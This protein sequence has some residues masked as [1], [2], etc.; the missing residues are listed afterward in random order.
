MDLRTAIS[1]VEVMKNFYRSIEYIGEVLEVA[2]GAEQYAAERSAEAQK[3]AE[4]IVERRKELA[5]VEA[6]TAKA[7]EEQSKQRREHEDALV[8]AEEQS[9]KQRAARMNEFEANFTKAMELATK[10]REALDAAVRR[11]ANIKA[12][13]EVEVAALTNELNHLKSR[14]AGA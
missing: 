7:R 11:L 14:I 10:Q 2:R 3:T 12:E 9:S 1:K 4:L 6:D 8:A 13:R 5:Q